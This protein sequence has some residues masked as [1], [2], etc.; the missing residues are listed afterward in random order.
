M[1]SITVFGNEVE[2]KDSLAV[3]LV[4]ELKKRFKKI[5]FQISDPTENVEPPSDPWIIIDVAVGINEVVVVEDLKKL[6][7]VKGSSVHDYDVYMDLRLR[8]KLG[9]L[10]SIKIILVPN[11]WD[12]KRA[13]INIEQ[14]IYNVLNII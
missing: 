10:P 2:G 13:L 14:F 9:Q 8:E 11:D 5:N 6:D 3:R 7:Y 4:P 12:E 1:I